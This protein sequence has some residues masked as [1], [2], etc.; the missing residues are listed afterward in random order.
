MC[1]QACVQEHA[2][3]TAPS[4]TAPSGGTTPSGAGGLAA[5]IGGG[6]VAANGAAAHGAAAATSQTLA[7]KSG[8]MASQAGLP[9]GLIQSTMKGL[10]VAVTHRYDAIVPVSMEELKFLNFGVRL[11]GY[12]E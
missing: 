2:S 1:K 5:T 6:G 10:G 9:S 4:E 8:S 3:G 7:A 11:E 12:Q